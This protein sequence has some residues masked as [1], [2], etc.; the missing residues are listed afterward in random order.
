LS[1][2]INDKYTLTTDYKLI[3]WSSATGY[4][5]FN[6][7]DQNVV[8][9]GGKYAGDGYW[10]GLGYNYAN[11]PIGTYAASTYR[12][13]VINFFNNEMFPAIVTSSYTLGGGYG[14]SKSLGID[15]SAVITPQVT[16]TV[17][18]S[19]MGGATTNTTSHS[20]QAVS[21]SLRYKF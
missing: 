18:I 14:I 13:A 21:L 7:S 16:K 10:L 19:Q 15:F 5:D 20:Q 11:D 9:V 2:A 6:W 1:Y 4:K 17:D 3:Q 8:A 12:N